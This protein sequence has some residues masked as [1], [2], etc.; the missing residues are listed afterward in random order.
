MTA[1]ASSAAQRSEHGLGGNRGHSGCRCG[2]VGGGFGLG[3]EF[4][5]DGGFGPGGG[6]GFG[7]GFRLRHGGRVRLGV[8]CLRRSSTPH[9]QLRVEWR[10]RVT[11]L[12]DYMYLQWC[13][14]RRFAVLQQVRSFKRV[15]LARLWLN[16][17]AR[18][19][20]R[21]LQR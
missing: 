8:G 9:D 13:E 6:F 1:F 2:C 7:L 10:E 20:G 17:R 14:N 21:L 19:N 3:G 16:R 5:V 18:D 11:N 15:L 12:L 4:G